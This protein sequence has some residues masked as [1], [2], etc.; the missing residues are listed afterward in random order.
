[1][2]YGLFLEGKKKAKKSMCVH[3]E[4]NPGLSRGRRKSCHWTIDANDSK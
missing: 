3:R 2:E 1:M 4:L